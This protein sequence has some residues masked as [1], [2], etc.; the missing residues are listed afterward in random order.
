MW[1]K[2]I[3]QTR[4]GTNKF[5]IN[6]PTDEAVIEF[7]RLRKKST[8]QGFAIKLSSKYIRLFYKC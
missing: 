6:I 7:R 1:G 3:K 8:Y 2:V 5:N 4:C